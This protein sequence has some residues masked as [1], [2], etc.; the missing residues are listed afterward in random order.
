M[1]KCIKIISYLVMTGFFSIALSG[2]GKKTV[3]EP[4]AKKVIVWS[5]E[6]EDAWRSIKKNFEKKNENFTLVYQQQ[7]L[8]SNYENKVLNSLLSGQG[9]DVWAMP[10]DWVYR[11]KDKLVPM[12]N[13]MSETV[14]IDNFVPA[15]KE[16]VYFDDTVY[17]LSPSADPLMIYYNPK[18]FS[19]VNDEIQDS[20]LPKEVKKEA[21]ELLDTPPRLWSDLV[22]SAN[23]LTKKENAQPISLIQPKYYIY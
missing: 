23:Y 3:V 12:P 20:D 1:K 19:K 7:T 11:H 4:N 18:M 13:E 16:S 10:N 15:I 8:D 9:P 17:A 6:H 14:D 22:K 2:C 5:F 21:N